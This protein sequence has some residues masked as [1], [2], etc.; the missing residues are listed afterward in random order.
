MDLRSDDSGLCQEPLSAPVL[1]VRLMKPLEGI[2]VF[3]AC[4]PRVHE[5]LVTDLLHEP[6][7]HGEA[8]RVPAWAIKETRAQGLWDL[9]PLLNLLGWQPYSKRAVHGANRGEGRATVVKDEAQ[10]EEETTGHSYDNKTLIAI[11]RV[12]CG[13][14]HDRG[15][16]NEQ[17]VGGDGIARPSRSLEAGRT[18]ASCVHMTE[19]A[20]TCHV[21]LTVR[22]RHL[23]PASSKPVDVSV[24]LM[25]PGYRRVH[26]QPAK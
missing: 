16:V 8:K 13:F 26:N 5:P 22:G 2:A 3:L 9:D 4:P 6:L 25:K 20:T 14:W 1:I 18:D 15:R 19:G 11:L 21:P 17:W 23:N 10:Q 7:D 12:R 24:G